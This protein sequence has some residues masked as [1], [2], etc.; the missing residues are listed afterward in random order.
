[1]NIPLKD[2]H[3]LLQLIAFIGLSIVSS[4][5]IMLIGL[6]G[7]I[8]FSGGE[9]LDSLM[10]NTQSEQYISYM[11]FLQL[12]SHLGMFIIPAIIFARLAGGKILEYYT[13]KNSGK[14]LAIFIAIL[15]VAFA[16]PLISLL[17]EWNANIS[18]PESMSETELWIKKSELDATRITELFLSTK[19]IGGLLFNIFLIAL[20]PAIGEELVF[21]GILQKLLQKWMK[22]P[23]IAIFIT[24]FVFSSFHM[25]FYGFIP[26]LLLGFVLGY[27]FY[28]SGKLWISILVHFVNNAGAVILYYLFAKGSINTHPDLLFNFNDNIPILILSIF[29]FA[30]SLIL[31]HNIFSKKASS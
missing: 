7:G 6:I 19:M 9:L 21:R 16:Q 3:P 24:A 12:L 11:K 10:Q 25:Q 31:F 20:I 23:W 27:L 26:R 22:N 8:I 28:R 18:L 15:I 13:L 14:V 5:I 29:L 2:K 30:G 17:T 1:M 4:I